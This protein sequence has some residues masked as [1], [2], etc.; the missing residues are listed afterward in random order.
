VVVILL[1]V[2]AAG[3][4]VYL[5][6]TPSR[7]SSTTSTASA[8][9]TSSAPPLFRVDYDNLTV[10]YN[11]GLWQ[12]ALTDISGQKIKLLTATLATPIESKLCTG[13]LGGFYFSNCAPTTYPDAGF[14][15]ANATFKGFATGA[16]PGSAKLGSTYTVTLNVVFADGTT[17]Q[18]VIYAKATGG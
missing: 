12:L 1:V 4:A 5:Y 18:D 10:G 2:G 17:R 15:P 3:V 14:F 11:S 7:T 9:S 6:A 13:A 8:T 16:G